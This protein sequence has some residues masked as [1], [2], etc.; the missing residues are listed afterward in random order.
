LF[1]AC[2]SGNSPS[3]WRF[4]QLPRPFRFG[5]TPCP[6]R[7]RLVPTWDAP[8]PD[9]EPPRSDLGRPCDQFGTTSFRLGTPPC[10]V[11]NHLVPSW[12][13]PVP[14][15]EPPGSDLG[16]PRARLGTAPFRLGTTPCSAENAAVC[17]RSRRARHRLTAGFFKGPR[18]PVPG[19]LCRGANSTTPFAAGSRPVPARV[20]RGTGACS[21]RTDPRYVWN[22]CLFPMYGPPLRVERV[23]VPDVRT[24]VTC[25]TGACSRG[26]DPRYM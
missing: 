23:P 10:P 15:S 16:R 5:I 17:S 9:S 6:T 24:P 4:F 2:R 22:G 12:D 21:P 1:A 18:S 14:G 26:T 19:L 11:R 3:P 13:Y 20:T 25:G 8:V 7:N